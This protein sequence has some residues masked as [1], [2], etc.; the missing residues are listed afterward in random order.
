[1][2]KKKFVFDPHNLNYKQVNKG[3]KYKISKSIIWIGSSL[4]IGLSIVI[5]FSL[6]FDTPRERDLRQENKSL[7]EDLEI[8]NQR[9]VRIDT[10]LK[11][12][13]YIDE[14]IYR[15]IFETDPVGNLDSM[16]SD[17]RQ[18]LLLFQQKNEKIVN[19][20]ADDARKLMEDVRNIS[21]SYLEL[22]NY[23]LEN[24]SIASNIPAIQ[25]ILNQ[26]LTRMAS[27][28][29]DR[30]H[31]FYKI[32]KFHSGMDFTAPTGTQVFATADGIVESIDKTGRGSGNTIIID[33]GNG[34]KTYYSH[35]SEFSVRQGTKIKRGMVVGLVGNTGLSVGPHLHYEVHLD[36]EPVNPV[37]YFFNELTPE[38]YDRMI[39]M[40]IKSGQSFD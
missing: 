11:E 8:L 3:L 38:Q 40:S 9:Y 37:N 4:F 21:Y 2:A 20:Y 5:L 18:I 26:D 7:S 35:L 30:M 29:G 10:V 34:Y 28:F 14:N 23:L 15:T 27:G 25:P 19:S 24:E 31:P 1:M 39:E 32:V 36:G 33:H 17:Q 12:L 6:L 16:R 13:S 22:K